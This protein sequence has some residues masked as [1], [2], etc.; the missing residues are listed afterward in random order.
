[1]T[2]LSEDRSVFV[3]YYFQGALL[4]NV[5]FLMNVLFFYFTPPFL[6][7]MPENTSVYGI[8]VQLPPPPFCRDA[9][10]TSSPA[11]AEPLLVIAGEV[12]AIYRY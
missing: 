5:N 7:L 11:N 12:R 9:K 4:L 3:S 1:M 6:S 10:H 2:I 8:M